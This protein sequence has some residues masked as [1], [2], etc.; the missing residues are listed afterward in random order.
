MPAAFQKRKIWHIKLFMSLMV[1]ILTCGCTNLVI[2]I[3]D[4]PRVKEFDNPPL[5][6]KDTE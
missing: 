3:A 1:T 4:V 2:N 6:S 5:S